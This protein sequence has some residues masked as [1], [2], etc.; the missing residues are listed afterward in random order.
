MRDYNHGNRPDASSISLW[1]P[2]RKPA[3]RT[4]VV[5]EPAAYGDFRIVVFHSRR[6]GRV[7]H[8]YKAIS[9]PIGFRRRKIRLKTVFMQRKRVDRLSQR[10]SK[11]TKGVRN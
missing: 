6:L 11:S 7:L 10:A 1:P 5:Y 4:P 2:F 3:R 9:V 8:I